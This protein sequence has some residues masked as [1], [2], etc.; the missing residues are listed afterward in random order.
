MITAE[1]AGILQLLTPETVAEVA[2]ILQLLTPE[3]VA[4]VGHR[5]PRRVAAVTAPQL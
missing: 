5:H 2:G 1:V 3:T 4:E